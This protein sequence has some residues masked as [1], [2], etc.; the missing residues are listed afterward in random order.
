MRLNGE[1]SLLGDA[2]LTALDLLVVE[3]LNVAA[4]R[5]D[6]MIV[7]LHGFAFEGGFARF[8]IMTF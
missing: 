7:V 2:C 8:E 1:A 6:Q 4:V 3:F 5:S